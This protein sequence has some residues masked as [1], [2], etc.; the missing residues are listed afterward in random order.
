M[1]THPPSGL[2]A[3]STFVGV[4]PFAPL[5]T[6]KLGF[7]KAP[8]DQVPIPSKPFAHHKSALR[9]HWLRAAPPVQPKGQDA[10][11][12]LPFQPL[13]PFLRI[14]PLFVSISDTNIL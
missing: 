11:P 2:C 4:Q 1:A 10:Q 8:P 6:V 13:L 7:A 12:I 14:I 9:D 5:I 3:A